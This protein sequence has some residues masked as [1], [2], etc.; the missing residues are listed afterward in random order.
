MCSGRSDPPAHIE[1]PKGHSVSP[2]KKSNA[3]SVSYSEKQSEGQGKT[4]ITRQE[5]EEV[6]IPLNYN[7]QLEVSNEGAKQIKVDLKTGQS[8]NQE[9]AQKAK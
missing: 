5:T 3:P 9:A 7:G 8:S 1:P 4:K 2:G 6:P